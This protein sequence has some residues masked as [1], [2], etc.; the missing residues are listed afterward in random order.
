MRDQLCVK[1]ITEIADREGVDPLELQP[2]LFEVIDP[3]ALESLF[4]PTARKAGTCPESVTFRY[5][6]YSVLVEYSK[7]AASSEIQLT[8]ESEQSDQK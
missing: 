1:I 6:E 4:R 5:R 3:S 2:P 8:I 7:S